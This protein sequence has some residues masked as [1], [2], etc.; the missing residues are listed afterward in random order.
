MN[1]VSVGTANIVVTTIIDFNNENSQFYIFGKNDMPE[2]IKMI[3]PPFTVLRASHGNSIK[4]LDAK[5]IK[6]NTIDTTKLLRNDVKFVL[7]KNN[8]SL[9]ILRLKDNVY[10]ETLPLYASSVKH[11]WENIVI[12]VKNY[13][14]LIQPTPITFPIHL[15][16]FEQMSKHKVMI[17]HLMEEYTVFKEYNV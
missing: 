10:T 17:G 11:T 7:H 6:T 1:A 8:N 9:G 2:F 3:N 15:T 4:T 5:L 16:E 12:M 13:I 14:S